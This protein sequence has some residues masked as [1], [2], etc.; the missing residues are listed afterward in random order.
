M[1][2]FGIAQKMGEKKRCSCCNQEQPIDMFY[3]DRRM[4]GGLSSCCRSC[5][6]KKHKEAMPD[7]KKRE[8]KRAYWKKYR[9]AN[10]AVVRA[11]EREYAERNAERLKLT[12]KYYPHLY[13]PV[14][15]GARNTVRRSI[16]SG[17]L[18]RPNACERCASKVNIQAHHEDYSKPLEVQWLCRKC[19]AKHHRKP[20]V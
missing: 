3:R 10:L 8:K 7:P 4:S 18:T 16:R 5:Y 17:L 12:R 6:S 9:Q 2:N 14:K 19:H 1:T 20:L 13:N 15:D 11:K